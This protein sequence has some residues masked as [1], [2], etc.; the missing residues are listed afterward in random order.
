MLYYVAASSSNLADALKR[1]SRYARLGN[2]ALVVRSRQQPACSVEL[3][4]SGVQR[5]QDRH[6]MELLAF[7]CLR[8]CRKLVGRN[9]SPTSVKFIHHRPGDIGQIRRLFGCAVEF[10]CDTDE[11]SFDIDVMGLPLVAADP[12]L[13]ELM[14]KMCD[15]ALAVRS[16]NVSPFRTVVENTIAPLLPHAEAT[17]RTVAKRLGLSER[18][19]ARRLA[20]EGLSFGEIP[21]QQRRDLA[22]RYLEENLQASQIAWLLNRIVRRGNGPEQLSMVNQRS[23]DRLVSRRLSAVLGLG[24]ADRVS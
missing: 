13:N 10:D 23:V 9:F 6:Q 22:L 2:E 15:D 1:L 4:Y 8:L 20:T 16:G 7:T 3:S 24:R 12:F 21:D 17:T 5:H 18:T 19:F 11:I 14:T